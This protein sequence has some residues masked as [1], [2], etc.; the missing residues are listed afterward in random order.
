MV[1]ADRYV[2]NDV[3]MVVTIA[4]VYIKIQTLNFD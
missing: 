4:G 1:I 3:Y 2:N